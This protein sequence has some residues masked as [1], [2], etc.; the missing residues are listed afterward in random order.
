MR[1]ELAPLTKR[2]LSSLYC[3]CR[4]GRV[5]LLSNLPLHFTYYIVLDTLRIQN[6][7]YSFN[8]KASRRLSEFFGSVRS[9][10]AVWH[11]LFRRYK[12]DSIKLV[13]NSSTQCGLWPLVGHPVGYMRCVGSGDS[14][15]VQCSRGFTAPATNNYAS[16]VIRLAECTAGHLIYFQARS[17]FVFYF[18]F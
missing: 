6:A 11:F 16:N 12:R 17:K 9:T 7:V 4:S 13:S 8:W 1:I 14:I 15:A 5:S 2:S 18:D 10:L 3:C